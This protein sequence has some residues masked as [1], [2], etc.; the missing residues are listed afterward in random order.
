MIAGNGDGMLYPAGDSL[1]RRD[2]RPAKRTPH[3]YPQR[4]CQGDPLRA[5]VGHY[6]TGYSV[7]VGNVWFSPCRCRQTP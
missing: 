1:V 6:S 2:W 4:G 3:H 7:L 5:D